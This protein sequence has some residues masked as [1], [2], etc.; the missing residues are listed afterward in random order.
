MTTAE[1][2]GAVSTRPQADCRRTWQDERPNRRSAERC[3]AICGMV[4]PPSRDLVLHGPRGN[5][6]TALL[7]WLQQEAAAYP[8]IDVLSLTPAGMPDETKLVERLLPASLVAAFRAGA[9]FRA[10]NHVAAGPARPA[11]AGRSLGRACAESAAAA[12]DR[13]GA[14]AR[15]RRRPRAVECRPAGGQKVAV[16]ARAGRHPEPS[17]PPECDGRDVLEPGRPASHRPAGR[18]GDGGGVAKSV[19]GA[20]PSR[21]TTTPSA[22]IVRDSHGYPYFVQL[23][24]QAVVASGGGGRPTG[25]DRRKGASRRRPSAP[26]SQPWTGRRTTT[27]WIAT[28][29]SRRYAL[30]PVARTVAEA[31]DTFPLLNDVQLETA[32]LRGLDATPGSQPTEAKDMLRNVGYVWRPDAK[33]AWE[34]GIPSLMDYEREHAP[35]TRS[36]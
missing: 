22:H 7:V 9:G 11:A 14:H 30:L 36:A 20:T 24:G 1:P 19:A 4:W 21:S 26:P 6:K 12:A 29:S 5:G 15:R 18:T 34:P 31:F 17:R 35:V 2:A 25:H 33:S 16:P 23:W 13:R 10:G 27:T 3:S 32:I 28:K 8:G